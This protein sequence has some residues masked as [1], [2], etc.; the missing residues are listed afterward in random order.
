MNEWMDDDE[1]FPN[2]HQAQLSTPINWNG[3]KYQH[4]CVGWWMSFLF[5]FF[6]YKSLHLHQSYI[7][8]FLGFWYISW[9]TLNFHTLKIRYN[10]TLV[11]FTKNM[12]LLLFFPMVCTILMTNVWHF[13]GELFIYKTRLS[14]LKL[15][16]WEF[17][18]LKNNSTKYTF[19]CL[20]ITQC[21]GQ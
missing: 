3:M 13:F 1:L 8:F 17:Q 11:F 4:V 10:Q 19:C 6:G 12:I 7:E 16:F 18:H 14:N 9:F 20:I 5:F 15:N 2:H 21:L